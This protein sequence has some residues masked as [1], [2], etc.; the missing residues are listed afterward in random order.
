MREWDSKGLSNSS[1]LFFVPEKIIKELKVP[2]SLSH[3]ICEDFLMIKLK[4][5]TW[6]VKSYSVIDGD[7]LLYLL[8]ATPKI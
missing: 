2:F 1:F 4:E 8:F 3:F 5:K 7:T 6:I